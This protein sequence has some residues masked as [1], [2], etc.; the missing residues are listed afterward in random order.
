[1]AIVTSR[2]LFT[3][4]VYKPEA[5]EITEAR[6]RISSDDT[7]FLCIR[8]ET[9]EAE[10]GKS[11]MRETVGC[12]G[13][14]ITVTPYFVKSTTVLRLASSKPH[15]PATL[16]RLILLLLSAGRGHSPLLASAQLLP[17]LLLLD[18]DGL[19]QH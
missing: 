6:N 15:M 2:M 19:N 18:R 17:Q 9:T 14:L 8:D 3:P 10:I 5:I 4:Q 1:M 13:H 11:G 12:R 7:I 16:Q